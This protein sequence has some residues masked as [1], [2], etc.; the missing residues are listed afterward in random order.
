MHR[1]VFAILP[2]VA[3]AIAI[4]A[5]LTAPL[6]QQVSSP[7]PEQLAAVDAAV[8]SAAGGDKAALATFLAANPN[9]AII[10]GDVVAT[11]LSTGA[12]GAANI[13]AALVQTSNVSLI[14]GV[15]IAANITPGAQQALA[16]AVAQ[17]GNASLA[18]QVALSVQQSGNT[19]ALAA[20]GTA[21]TGT[22]VAGAVAAN[23]VAPPPQTV[24][25]SPAQIVSGSIS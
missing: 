7:T 14:A 6:A 4:A 3:G 16:T 17:S 2:L 25:P 13:A 1:R 22:S 10:V 12:T 11:R 21:A 15:M 24:V 9:L 23:S 5:P 19:A 8:N 20:L 18:G